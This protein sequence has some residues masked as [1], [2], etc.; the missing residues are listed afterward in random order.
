M[1]IILK[2]WIIF[3]SILCFSL[4]IF[5]TFLVRSGILTSV[6][7]FAADA[8]RGLFILLIFFI[9]TGFGFLVFLLKKPETSKPITLL[10]INKFSALIFNNILMIIATLT[11]LLGTIY[12]IIVEV[13][14]NKR[15]SV[16]APYFNSTVIPIM[17]PGFLL[18]SIAPILSWQ[19][20][21]IRS[22]RNYV[23]FFIL[24]SLII[25][26]QSYFSK[27]NTWGIVGLILGSWI[28]FASLFA[29]L[30]SYKFKF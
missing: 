9:I 20:N 7:S 23:I 11:V 10:F 3:L 6:H 30:T 5:G 29:V 4:S 1:S 25:V 27:F 28:I 2:R 16:G 12:P 8:S 22:A 19:T 24:I 18:M 26:I 13:L 21:K 14:T 15:I 17:I